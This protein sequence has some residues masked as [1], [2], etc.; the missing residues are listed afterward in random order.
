MNNDFKNGCVNEDCRYLG[1][2]GQC[3][4]P[5]P[6]WDGYNSYKREEDKVKEEQE[7]KNDPVN[8]PKHY[9]M[10]K[11]EVIHFIQDKKLNFARG[12]A[13]KYIVRAGIKD[14]EKEIEDLEKAI[15]YLRAE[16]EDILKRRIEE[17]NEE[18]VL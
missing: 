2:L 6:C 12:N 8:H 11:I 9:T 3:M 10:G 1:Y 18:N 4:H 7:E 17:K 13:V 16:I 14:P 5:H 15:F